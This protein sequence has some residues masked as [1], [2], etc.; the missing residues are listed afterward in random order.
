[1][2]KE[3]RKKIQEAENLLVRASEIITECF[4]EENEAYDNLPESIQ[5]GERGD[6]M[7]EYIDL[8]SEAIE[9]LDTVCTDLKRITEE[10]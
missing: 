9:D 8:M 7:T 6:E 5:L 1:M 4:E 2:N 10:E 3:R